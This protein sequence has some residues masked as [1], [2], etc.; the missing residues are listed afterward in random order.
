[1][2]VAGEVLFLFCVCMHV[3][4]YVHI[5]MC[6]VCVCMMS[7]ILL[8]F[9]PVLFI[10][11]EF[12][13]MKKQTNKN[14]PKLTYKT[15][16]INQ[17]ALLWGS[18]VSLWKAKTQRAFMGNQ[19]RILIFVLQVFKHWVISLALNSHLLLKVISLRIFAMYFI[20][21]KSS[22]VHPHVPTQQP[23]LSP[24]SPSSHPS[25]PPLPPAFLSNSLKLYWPTTL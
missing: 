23:V 25:L 24:L 9:S 21:K 12:F 19:N 1:M 11:A 3:C 17:L 7:G 15:S 22:Q 16:L 18:Q 6:S 5:H 8:T 20:V 2:C 13:K 4:M 14:K 10:E